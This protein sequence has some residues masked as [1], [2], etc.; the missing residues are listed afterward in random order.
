V[1]V[2]SNG[3]KTY[4]GTDIAYHQEK[5]ERGFEKLIDIWGADHHGEIARTQGALKALGYENKLDVILTQ[6]VRILKDGEEMKMSK[7]AGTYVSVD[8][9]IEEVGCDATRFFFLMH[10]ADTHMNFD[11]DLAKERSEKNPV[12]YVQY[13]HARIASILRK[14]EDLIL[15]LNSRKEIHAKERALIFELL[16]F[17]DL[18]EEISQNYAVHYLSQYA[19]GLADKFHSFYSECRVI[20]EK[21]LELTAA[22]LE[23]VKAV[24]IVLAETLKLMG[25]SA[26]QR[27]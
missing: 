2:K 14:A 27:M 25:I 19:M 21:N 16:K 13:A 5:L 15:E 18:V 22:R 26:P 1:V 6:F 17:P 3:E 23:L 7:R 24:R 12:Y 20:D 11:M 8:D 4:F 9:L 10:S